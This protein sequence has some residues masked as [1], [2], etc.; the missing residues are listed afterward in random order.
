MLLAFDASATV[1]AVVGAIATAG[2]SIFVARR[3]DNESDRRKLA[4]ALGLVATEVHENAKR[5]SS[6][7]G[8][9]SLTL[10]DWQGTKGTLI[11]LASR[12]EQLWETLAETYRSTFEA[13]VGRGDPPAVD[14]LEQLSERLRAEGKTLERR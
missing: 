1:A 14:A 11:S 2:A 5:L 6:D 3:M 12:D 7:L 4:A 13:Q 10:G 9:G 8:P